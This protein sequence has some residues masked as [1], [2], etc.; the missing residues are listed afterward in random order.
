MWFSQT[1]TKEQLVQRL[2]LWKKRDGPYGVHD[3]SELEFVQEAREKEKEEKEAEEKEADEKGEADGQTFI[4]IDTDD[5]GK[6]RAT[7]ITGDFFK[8]SVVCCTCL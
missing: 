2:V 3:Y 7:D 4:G 1:G 6:R 8:V 5:D